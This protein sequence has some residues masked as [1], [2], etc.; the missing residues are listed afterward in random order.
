M[1]Q[2]PWPGPYHRPGA[3]GA[4]EEYRTE[5]LIRTV[6]GALARWALRERHLSVPLGVPVGLWSA[7][8]LAHVRHLGHGLGYAA[9]AAEALT[10]IIAGRKYD[11]WA[12]MVY[13]DLTAAGAGAWLYG[14]A[15]TGLTRPLDAALLAGSAAWGGVFWW[16]KRP[17]DRRE[18]KR[19]AAEVEWWDGE[20]WGGHAQ[21]WGVPGSHVVD[22]GSTEAVTSLLVQVVRGRQTLD[23]LRG[24]LRLIESA[25]DGI[26]GAEV[27]H[28][29]IRLERVSASKAWLHL[30]HANPLRKAITWDES[31]VPTDITQ[32]APLGVRESGGWLAECLRKSTFT[33]GVTRSGKSNQ[34]SVRYAT[35]T[36]CTNARLWLIDM[37]GGRSMRPWL[38]AIDWPAV[39]MAEATL[40]LACAVAETKARA[41]HAYN[42]EDE[43][44]TPTDEVP[45]IFTDIDE[46]YEVTAMHLGAAAARLAADLA[47]LASQ[48]AGVEM[49]TDVTTQYGSLEASVRT[50]QTRSNLRRRMCFQVE[51][52]DH[53][54]FALGEDARG[55][56]D[57]SKMEEA[58]TFY[59]REGSKTTLEQIRAPEIPYKQVHKIAARNAARTSLHERRL[60]LYCGAEPCPLM[61]GKTWQQVY[62][63]RWSRLPQEFHADA[64]RGVTL[65]PSPAEQEAPVPTKI[66]IE[67]PAEVLTAVRRIDAEA[68]EHDHVTGDDIA[69]ARARRAARGEAP[70]DPAADHG[71]RMRAFADAFDAAGPEG[72]TPRALEQASGF[73]REWVRKLRNA[74]VE[75]GAAQKVRTGL[76]RPLTGI[77]AELEAMRIEDER[78]AAEA[79]EMAGI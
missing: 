34:S 3:H 17:R 77:R 79:R 11:R 22:V 59:Y 75:R 9:F 72:I 74:L 70:F 1:T 6:P 13:A 45:T 14:A 19:H 32:P 42:G 30:K 66:N 27:P 28:G 41:T 60:L 31:L 15:N 38:A 21:A 12:E 47:T 18:R 61:P 37:K 76:Y 46:A 63:E 62:D 26:D 51:S 53:G 52:A 20:F 65:T 44:L 67:Y 40:M 71:R 68:A 23:H 2:D 69:A 24:S 57:A 16:H 8:A 10:A 25:L 73:S 50:E 35:I 33:N 5:S 39:T 49:Y 56:A 58:G 7:G 54:E 4:D 78:L 64:P 29:M 48:G 43:Q 55:A 36:N